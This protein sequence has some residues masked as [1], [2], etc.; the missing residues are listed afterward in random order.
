MMTRILLI[1]FSGLMAAGAPAQTLDQILDKYYE[2]TGGLARW[3]AQTTRTATGKMTMQGMEFPVT[4]Y[5]KAPVL[6][7]MII[8]VQGKELV[9]AYDGK[10]AWTI[11]PFA[12]GTAATRMSDEEAKEF[13][14]N[15]FE[16]EFIDF[17]K[18]GHEVSLQGTEE[19]D[20]VKCFKVELIKN[21]HN[22]LEDATEI[23]YFDSENFVPIM[24]KSYARTGPAKGQ[25]IMT[26]FSDYQEVDGLMFPFYI[27]S[28][29]AGQTVQK[30]TVEKITLNEKLDDSL[31]AFPNK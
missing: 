17:Q 18:K 9:Q 12:G 21:K 29:V 25:E 7:K 31:F 11:N 5:E 4:M 15:Y 6:Q 30:I 19:I 16:D 28:K 10:D 26:Y 3:K 8:N 24:M 14:D 1:L 27:E 13:K 2:N 23:H 20:G 22:D